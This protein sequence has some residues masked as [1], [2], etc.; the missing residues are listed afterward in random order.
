MLRSHFLLDDE[1]SLLQT[2]GPLLLLL[3]FPVTSLLS[4]ICSPPLR[5]D[6]GLRPLE[7]LSPFTFQNLILIPGPINCYLQTSAF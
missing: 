4:L 6:G 1:A 7:S 2:G 5:A 3:K